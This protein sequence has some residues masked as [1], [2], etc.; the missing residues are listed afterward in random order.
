MSAVTIAVVL[1]RNAFEIAVAGRAGTINSAYS[2]A[3]PSWAISSAV[4]K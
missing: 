1:G 3:K 4:S 2:A